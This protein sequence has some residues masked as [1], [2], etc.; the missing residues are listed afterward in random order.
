[1]KT[2][3]TTGHNGRWTVEEHQAF[4]AAVN[5]YGRDWQMVS[6]KVGTRAPTQVRVG[7]LILSRKP[8]SDQTV[9][10]PGKE[11]RAEIL[12]EARG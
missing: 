3:G 4:I 1:M 11:P 8:D 5:Q 7:S 12:R 10:H 9:T 6:T 2:T